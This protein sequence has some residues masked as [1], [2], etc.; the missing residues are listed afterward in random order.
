MSKKDNI[1]KWSIVSIFVLLY[2]GVSIISTIH[3]IDFF[4]LS[5]PEWLAITLAIAFEIG[6]AAC[7]GAIV[8]LDRTSRWLVWALFILITGMQMMGNMYYAYSHL[9]DYQGW[10]ELFGLNE[11]ELIYQKRILSIVSGAILPIVALGFIKSLVDYIRPSEEKAPELIQEKP[12]TR[13]QEDAERVW[14]DVARR[15]ANGE[16]QEPTEEEL[17]DE[18]T[19]LANSG[20]RERAEME[21]YEDE[22]EEEEIEDLVEDAIEDVEGTIDD[23]QAD[24]SLTEAEKNKKIEKKVKQAILQNPELKEKIAEEIKKLEKEDKYTNIENSPIAN[25]NIDSRRTFGGM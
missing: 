12:K 10:I 5:N 13:L 3:V 19:A 24:D 14:A 21:Q 20:Y 23:I 4:R 2:A 1:V 11:E 25:I 15:K 16:I 18:P 17:A 22:E 7:L 6:A 8:I 9:Q